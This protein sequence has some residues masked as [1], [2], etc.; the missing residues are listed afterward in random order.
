MLGYL[1]WER[2]QKEVK[3]NKT[4][5]QIK[6][7]IV[8]WL[9]PIIK[10]KTLVFFFSIVNIY[11]LLHIYILYSSWL[12]PGLPCTLCHLTG[13]QFPLFSLVTW[14]RVMLLLLRTE[15]SLDEIQHGSTEKAWGFAPGAL[16]KHLKD[17]QGSSANAPLGAT[18]CVP[19]AVE[20]PAEQPVTYYSGW[21][22]WGTIWSPL[23]QQKNPKSQNLEMQWDIL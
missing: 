13:F 21:L 18:G 15:H 22:R 7:S 3:W 17:E 8:C 2:V 16:E 1:L 14:S 11:M 10:C 12:Y 5:Q 6:T 20:S 4:Q 23:Q 19:R 9:Y